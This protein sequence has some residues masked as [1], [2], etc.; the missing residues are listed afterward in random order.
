MRPP[1]IVDSF[2]RWHASTVPAR[3]LATVDSTLPRRSRRPPPA[4]ACRGRTRLPR[5]RRR[6]PWR[7]R[8]GRGAATVA[9]R[10]RHREGGRCG[11]GADSAGSQRTRG[12][13]SVLRLQG[14]AASVDVAA[15]VD[16]DLA[17]G[18]VADDRSEARN[19]TQPAT[20]C[21]WPARP[22]GT[23]VDDRSMRSG[24][25]RPAVMSV[26]MKLGQ[27]ALT[28][29]LSGPSSR[30]RPWCSRGSPPWPPS[31]ASRRTRRRR[32]ARIPSSC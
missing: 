9:G 12:V 23:L 20:S 1:E 19:S 8:S 16:V 17:A 25:I 32:A 30:A 11:G 26:S 24:V 7:P 5:R 29:M 14:G 15:A 4:P 13:D 22:I 27:I 28:R 2:V 31:S 3:V 10:R 6:R 21:A 18:D